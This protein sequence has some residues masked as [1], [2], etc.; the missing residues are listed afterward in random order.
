M[1]KLKTHRASAKRFKKRANGLKRQ[2]AYGTHKLGKR[3]SKRKR[4]L[5]KN[6]PVDEANLAGV[7]RSLGMR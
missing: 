4:A 5:R 6:L 3:S 1:P 7:Y 2:K